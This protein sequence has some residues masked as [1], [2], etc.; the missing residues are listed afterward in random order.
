MK[1]ID[2]KTTN[3]RF[4]EAAGPYSSTKAK[5]LLLMPIYRGLNALHTLRVKL[6]GSGRLL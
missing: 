5:S 2:H 1:C 3:Q 4:I 6:L